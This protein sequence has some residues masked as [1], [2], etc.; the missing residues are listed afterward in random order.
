MVE[1]GR[2][3]E[4]NSYYRHPHAFENCLGDQYLYA[5]NRIYRQIRDCS[6]R[7]GLCYCGEGSTLWHDYQVCPL[8]C[9]NLMLAN[10]SVPMVDN[11][12]SLVRIAAMG[13]PSFAVSSKFLTKVFKRNY[14]LHESAH[15]IAHH[16]IGLNSSSMH[17]SIF[18]SEEERAV[19]AALLGE[20]FATTAERLAWALADNR[21][22][23][24]L[25]NLN[26]Y[27]DYREPNHNM[28]TEC[29]ESFGVPAMLRLG[30]TASFLNNLKKAPVTDLECNAILDHLFPGIKDNVATEKLRPLVAH[31]FSV[32]P[33]FFEETTPA[34]FR[35]LGREKVFVEMSGRN[36]SLDELENIME[37]IMPKLLE[38]ITPAQNEIYIQTAS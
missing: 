13:G 29:L 27:V 25:L 24:L 22:H 26:S 3:L 1:L 19:A 31:V 15:Y 12:S 9:L 38:I 7:Y 18:A 20:A 34:Y 5:R 10:K 32:A 8:F 4:I 23:I 2:L 6:L 33:A 37:P 14:L 35:L 21:T 30:M 17:D 28:V 11:T 16:I 36:F